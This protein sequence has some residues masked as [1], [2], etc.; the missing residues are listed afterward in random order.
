MMPNVILGVALC[1][2]IS[3]ACVCWVIASVFRGVNVDF[4]V[5]VEVKGR[6]GSDA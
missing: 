5:R 4:H 3:T 6:D 1:L 2:S